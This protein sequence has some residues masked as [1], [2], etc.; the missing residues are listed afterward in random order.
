MFRFSLTLSFLL[1]TAFGQQC[2]NESL[3]NISLFSSNDSLVATENHFPIYK[4]HLFWSLNWPYLLPFSRNYAN[5]RQLICICPQ[6]PTLGRV[7][8]LT[9]RADPENFSDGSK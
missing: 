9:L 1:T 6:Q 4:Q 7:I 8:P 5:N 3:T 2:P